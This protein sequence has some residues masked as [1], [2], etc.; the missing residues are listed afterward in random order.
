MS[1]HTHCWTISHYVQLGL[2]TREHLRECSLQWVCT[3][4]VWI[5]F[6]GELRAGIPL[7]QPEQWEALAAAEQR[8]QTPEAQQARQQQQWRL[9]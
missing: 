8:Q 7:G 4:G 6:S 1:Q 5:M 2:P 9:S 3:C